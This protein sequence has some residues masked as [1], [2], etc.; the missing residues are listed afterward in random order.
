MCA[1]C[2][3]CVILG[4]TSWLHVLCA[5][6]H[7][8]D[9]AA[10]ASLALQGLEAYM[11]PREREARLAAMTVVQRG[12]MVMAAA[13]MGMV[14]PALPAGE[15]EEAWAE[16]GEEEG[17][18]EEGEEQGL[19]DEGGVQREAQEEEGYDGRAE[20]GRGD[21]HGVRQQHRGRGVGGGAVQAWGGGGGW[22][23]YGA[24][25]AAMPGFAP[26][27]GYAPGAVGQQRFIPTYDDL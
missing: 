12:M 27:V 25:P 22:G 9:S 7:R 23:G 4:I 16:Q 14:L 3:L 15:D 24:W 6:V 1:A 5:L 26:A 11:N 8:V 13:G 20:G 17:G 19:C 10:C 21:R 18:V 2:A